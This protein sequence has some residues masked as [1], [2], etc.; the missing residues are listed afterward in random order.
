MQKVEGH[1]HETTQNR[2][3]TPCHMSGWVTLRLHGR[4]ERFQAV[5]DAYAVYHVR[6]HS[7]MKLK[8]NCLKTVL[9]HFVARIR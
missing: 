5:D 1:V 6:P 4:Q 3:R 9:F 7:E 8:Q 2:T